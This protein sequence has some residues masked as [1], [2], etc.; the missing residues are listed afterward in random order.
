MSVQIIPYA[1]W[2]TCLRL[3][4][5]EI[6]LVVTAE[7]GPRVIRFGFAGGPNEFAEYPEQCGLTGDDQWHAY[8]GHRLWHSPEVRPRTTYPDNRPVE[9]CLEDQTLV[10]RAPV[11]TTTG[12]QKEIRLWL[13]PMGNH[14]HVT[15][16]LSN[17]GPWAVP[18]AAWA[19]SVMAPG[20]RAIVPQETHV[21]HTERLLPVRPLALWGYTDM[22]DARFTWGRRFIQLRQDSQAQTP[23]KFGVLCTL[24]WAAY[25]HDDHLFLKR[26]PYVPDA[27]YPDFGCNAEFFTNHRMLEVES[28]GP[29]TDLGAGESLTHEEDWYLF[30]G[31]AVG[32]TEEAIG[33]ALQPLLPRARG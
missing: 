20:G 8:G 4:N 6:D 25:V 32:V 16:R 12:I 26:F 3:S 2:Q 17:C 5:A 1:G 10:L 31:V 18:L 23:Q 33:A 9:W 15:H 14:V 28:L 13:D 11:E 27:T 24:G 19:I 30:R 7:V 22:S 21:S 29:M